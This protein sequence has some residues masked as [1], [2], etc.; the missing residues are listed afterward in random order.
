MIKKT[1][2]C[3]II[4]DI[5]T[6]KPIEGPKH[7]LKYKKKC[8]YCN[9]T[10]TFT[11]STTLSATISGH[12]ICPKCKKDSP[13]LIEADMSKERDKSRNEKNTKS[14]NYSYNSN[15]DIINE[16]DTT[17]SSYEDN[18][19]E[20]DDIQTTILNHT[21]LF[22]D[23][24]LE[25][26]Q[27]N[28][29]KFMIGIQFNKNKSEKLES[30][31]KELKNNDFYFD[32]RSSLKTII[33]HNNADNVIDTLD[34][35]KINLDEALLSEWHNNKISEEIIKY[36]HGNSIYYF[37]Y[38]K[39]NIHF[40]INSFLLL[41]QNRLEE[42]ENILQLNKKQSTFIDKKNKS[43]SIAYYLWLCS[44]FGIFGF[45]RFYLGKIQ[46]GL[47]WFFT[48]G[49]LTIGALYDLFTLKKQVKEYNDN[50]IF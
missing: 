8:N 43:L 14:D 46:T 3:E 39:K 32:L 9:Y 40:R 29:K 2:G 30:F 6:D 1:S 4:E 25:K 20:V 22:T 50:K 18:Q 10:D 7:H 47:L 28:P 23:S 42:F 38:D 15:D 31:L 44:F 16:S 26:A 41:D 35:D 33:T 27:K 13:F 45:H 36:Q 34:Y 12:Y 19:E 21:K 48:C 17:M 24:V 5:V 11:Q 49:L 37:L